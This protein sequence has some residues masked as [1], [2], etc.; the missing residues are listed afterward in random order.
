MTAPQRPP[1]NR[2]SRRRFLGA[3]AA[4]GVAAAAAGA[5]RC[6]DGKRHTQTASTPAPAPTPSR[7]PAGTRGAIAR[8]YNFDA[9]RYDTLDPHL[10]G[11]GPV[12]NM[13]A[14]V[15]SRIVRYDD[16]RALTIAPD[17]AAAMPEQ[18]DATTYIIR[19]RDGVALHAAANHRYAYPKTAGRALTADDVKS[20]I[21][22]Q[23]NRNSPQVRRFFRSGNWNVIDKIDVRDPQ[24]VV[25]TTKSPVAPFLNFL[26]GRHAFIVPREVADRTDQINNVN[27]IIGTGPFLLDSFEPEMAMRLRRNPSWFAR[28]DDPG[29]VGAG[30]PFLDGYDAFFSPQEDTFQ[31]VAFERRIVDATSFA[32]PAALDLERKTNLADIALDETDAGGFLACRLLLDRPP[33][34]DDRVRRAIHLALDRTAL[35]DVIYPKFDGQPSARLSG[36]I[37]PAMDAFAIAPDDLRRRPGYRSDP[38]GRDEDRRTAKQLWSAALG[39][40][41]VAELRVLFAGVPRIIPDRAIDAFTRQ[42]QDVLGVSVNAATDFTG[43]ALI[44]AAYM[45]NIEGATEGVVPF[46]FALEDGGVDLDDWLYPHFRSGQPQN[47]YKLQDPQLDALLDKSRAEFD[48]DARRK[49]G[50]DVQ[51]Y[52]LAK[53]NARLEICAP[54]DRRLTWGYLRNHTAPIWYGATQSLADVWLDTKHPAWRPR[55]T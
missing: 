2:V 26:A 49:I 34:R 8:V 19:L 50:R 15:Y 47:T 45:R 7:V 42:L 6:G 29:G 35:A 18:P 14:A 12:A 43:D 16:E 36:A 5:I 23:L 41:P 11:M 37:A 25:I 4:L 3:S 33:F 39:D 20:S 40:A 22:R 1:A 17:L 44:A 31:R 30:R 9:M 13:H 54:I 24:T 27:A 38:A 28:D 32:D 46:T 51:D 48:N 55:P 10:T 52:L 21:E 53:V